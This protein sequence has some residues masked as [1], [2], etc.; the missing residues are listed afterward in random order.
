MKK[1]KIESICRLAGMVPAARANINGAEVFIADGFS[2]PPHI[3]FQRFGIEPTDHSF[4]MYATLWWVSN[5]DESLDVGQPIFFDA[6]HDSRYST[7]D[8]KRMRISA[9]RKAAEEFLVRWRAKVK[10][11]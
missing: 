5:G 3:N 4:G 1:H 10:A 7:E 11:H 8:R 2:A 6:F 9:A